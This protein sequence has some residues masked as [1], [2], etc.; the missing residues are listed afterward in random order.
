MSPMFFTFNGCESFLAL[1][2]FDIV[3]KNVY[4]K[5]K[6]C[7]LDVKC[8]VGEGLNLSATNFTKCVSVIL[9]KRKEKKRKE[10][11]DMRGCRQII[12]SFFN[13]T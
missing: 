4:C 5:I 3:G 12:M 1:L 7:F 10:K 9:K 6:C 13:Q 2:L 11:K 8:I